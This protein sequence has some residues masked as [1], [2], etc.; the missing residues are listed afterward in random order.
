MKIKNMTAIDEIK[1]LRAENETLK[2]KNKTFIQGANSAIA[3][4]REELM[5]M[6]K[7]NYQLTMFKQ[8]VF[9]DI[10]PDDIVKF[11]P[12]CFHG[13]F[14]EKYEKQFEQIKD[15]IY[16][17]TIFK[18]DA[19]YLVLHLNNEQLEKFAGIYE[20]VYKLPASTVEFSVIKNKISNSENVEKFNY[21][22]CDIKNID[23]LIAEL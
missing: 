1:K 14:L 6:Y 4:L 20:L 9:N 22:M 16:Y 17:L 3:N 21:Y 10:Q 19:S 5:K 11:N 7:I 8:G 18:A 12:D 13:R 23:K 2:E 15:E